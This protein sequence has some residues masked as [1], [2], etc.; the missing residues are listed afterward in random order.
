M[1]LY[2]AENI[3]TN[4]YYRIYLG[5]ETGE[6]IE[7]HVKDASTEIITAERLGI[8]VNLFGRVTE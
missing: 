5:I 2:V 3:R 8:G 1:T 7:T 6:C 4:E